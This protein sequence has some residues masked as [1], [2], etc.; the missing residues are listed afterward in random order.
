MVE[1]LDGND[2]SDNDSWGLGDG[3]ED[4]DNDYLG[5]DLTH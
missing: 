2:W 4:L 3:E 5:G 1:A